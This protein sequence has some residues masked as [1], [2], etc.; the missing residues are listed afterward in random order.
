MTPTGRNRMRC[1]CSISCRTRTAIPDPRS[2]LRGRRVSSFGG[3]CWTG[4]EKD[5]LAVPDADHMLKDG[6]QIRNVHKGAEFVKCYGRVTVSI[7]TT[8]VNEQGVVDLPVVDFIENTLDFT[9]PRCFLRQ[10]L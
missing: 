2:S 9:G 1:G 10:Y 7:G 8:L 5:A 6:A 4:T 3:S